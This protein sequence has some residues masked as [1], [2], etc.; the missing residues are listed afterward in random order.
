M[1]CGKILVS[2]IA[3]GRIRSVDTREA[4]ALPGILCVLTG[5]DVTD[6]KFGVSPARYDEHILAKDR[7]RYVG[8]EV[9]A[10]CAEDEQ[11]AERALRLIRVEPHCSLARFEHHGDKITLW[12]STQVPH[13]LH[14]M[15]SRTLGIPQGKIR[16]IKPAVGG[17]FGGRAETTKLDLL[18]IL[19][20][21]RTGR[22][23][24]MKCSRREMFYHH[25]GRHAQHMRMK[26]GMR[27]DGKLT[28]VQSRIFLDGGAYTRF[29]VITAYYAGSTL[30]TLYHSPAYRYEGFRMFTN[31]PACGAMR[32]HGVPQPRFA[33]ESLLDECALELGLD[34]IDVRLINA[35]DPNTRA[36]NDLHVLSCE[37]KATL[38]QAREKSD[39]DEKR[40]PGALPRGPREGGLLLG[41]RGRSPRDRQAGVVRN[42]CTSDMN[43]L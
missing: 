31:L 26:I 6:T 24:Q 15:L 12:S 9:A 37:L 42:C 2:P 19:F 39:W 3:H 43:L 7:E 18:S 10:V 4:E 5:R 21:Q 23:V 34:P 35:M 27:K 33:F 17:G 41:L 29:G 11:T 20:A 36:V 1:I 8:D 13:C 30:P 38:V 14:H 40:R 16:V 28:G 22:P 32:G 25:R